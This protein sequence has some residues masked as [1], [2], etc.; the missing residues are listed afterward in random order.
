MAEDELQ[1]LFQLKIQE[2]KRKLEALELKKE[3]KEKDAMFKALGGKVYDGRIYNSKTHQYKGHT[4]KAGQ[5]IR[6]WRTVGVTNINYWDNLIETKIIKIG[7][8]FEVTRSKT[9]QVEQSGV[10]PFWD[11]E[12]ETL[13]AADPTNPKLYPLKQCKLIPSC[14]NNELLDELENQRNDWTN[15]MMETRWGG[16]LNSTENIDNVAVAD[17]QKTYSQDNANINSVDAFESKN[18]DIDMKENDT[19]TIEEQ[20][21]DAQQ[22]QEMNIDQINAETDAFESKNNDIDM[23]ENDTTTI[24]EQNDDAQQVQ[25]MNIDQ[26][27]AETDTKNNDIDTNMK[28]NNTA[29]ITE[30]NADTQQLQE[31]VIDEV[32]AEIDAVL[33]FN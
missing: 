29:I 12:V 2:N 19:T 28:D 25:E 8:A 17:E 30:P 31:V 27:N 18:N 4:L 10:P 26:I 22:V 15:R 1:R 13:P 3:R 32:N 9:I 7:D 6:Y 23:K 24:E 16:F 11:T 5:S 21:D 33:Q 14:V 20:N